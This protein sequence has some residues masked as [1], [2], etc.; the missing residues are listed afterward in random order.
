MDY[1][2]RNGVAF[3]ITVSIFYS[4]RTFFEVL[5]RGLELTPGLFRSFPKVTAQ[6]LPETELLALVWLMFKL[7]DIDG[8]LI[9]VASLPRI[10]LPSQKYTLY[11]TRT[12]SL[13][14][15]PRGSSSVIVLA[16]TNSID[17]YDPDVK[18]MIERGECIAILGDE[19]AGE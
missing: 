14:M 9:Q 13:S 7:R 3:R 17:P 15:G 8:F 12:M 2:S 10:P 18:I 4:T 16:D 11:A 1:S 6:I 5:Q 19:N